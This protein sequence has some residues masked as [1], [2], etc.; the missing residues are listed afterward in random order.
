MAEAG[1]DLREA[2]ERDGYA[3]VEGVF[4]AEQC[5]DM[6]SEI[7]ALMPERFTPGDP[8]TWTGR[9]QDC[10]N[11]LPLYQRNGLLRY[12]DRKGFRKSRVF[13]R[14]V[15]ANA[16]VGE[17][18]A[19]ATGRRMERAHIRGLHPI[20]PMP[21][22]ISLNEAVGNR[23]ARDESRGWPK[24]P[25]PPLI[26]I[27]GHLDAHCTDVLMIAYLDDVP[28]RGGGLSVWPGSHRLLRDCFESLHDFLP[29]AAY[30]PVMRVLQRYRP[31]EIGGR[32]GDVV[33][34]DNRL[35]HTNSFNFGP[36]IR[37]AILL[38]AFGDDIAGRDR[39]WRAGD[40]GRGAMLA[41][42]A[43][44]APD[45][46]GASGIKLRRDPMRAFWS[47]L[48]KLR[49]FVSGIAKDPSAKARR[50][51]SAKIRQRQAGD[52]WVVVSQGSEHRDSF[53]LDAYGVPAAGKF[54]MRLNSGKP[55]KSIGGSLVERIELADG[56][57]CI[58]I[59]GRFSVDHYVRVIRSR[60]PI[61]ESDL[62][63]SGVIAAGHEQRAL[64]IR[65]KS[66]APLPS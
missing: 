58:H 54:R 63:F 40:S 6:L 4:D 12:K 23:L 53:K 59:G 47:R 61:N 49:G 8:A 62:L 26:P 51:L 37:Q 13:A 11:N 55:L 27:P 5:K 66:P 25:R 38:D 31:V 32:M 18:F 33:V 39:K 9:I 14:H 15:Y 34:F 44:G 7:W 16:R 43:T 3:V 17:A 50:M 65:I 42:R 20:L 48:P 22:W 29:N 36:R 30:K 1:V 28:E 19:A 41:S 57:N 10:C 21:R 52:F 35:L 64:D 60:N 2:F 46:A 45:I 56:D 24:V